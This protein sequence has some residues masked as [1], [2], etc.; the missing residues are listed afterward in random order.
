[1]L[2]D[3]PEGMFRDMPERIMRALYEAE[4]PAEEPTGWAEFGLTK[5]FPDKDEQFKQNAVREMM[6]YFVEVDGQKFYAYGDPAA[7]P[8]KKNGQNGI[9]GA[10]NHALNAYEKVAKAYV[11]AGGKN[12]GELTV[13]LKEY[14]E[15][16][17][18]QAVNAYLDSK[19]ETE[20][21]QAEPGLEVPPAP[22]PVGGAAYAN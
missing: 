14:T 20:P 4:R 13:K 6:N 8:V 12:L 22:G 1:M 18:R 3:K 7:T 2:R 5:P 17:V 21:E 16:K 9:N 19:I 11:E 10:A 15:E